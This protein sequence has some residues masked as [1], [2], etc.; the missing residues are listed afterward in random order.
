MSTFVSIVIAEDSLRA[1]ST[2]EC[3]KSSHTQ[4]TGVKHLFFFLR[5]CLC[6]RC[7]KICSASGRAQSN[8]LC[9][10]VVKFSYPAHFLNMLNSLFQHFSV[11]CR[12]EA[13]QELVC[14]IELWCWVRMGVG[15]LHLFIGQVFAVA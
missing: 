7:R 9:G 4:R 3:D 10:V 11:S 1:Q 15:N 12:S 2:E 8:S 14:K 5:L 13:H 6:I